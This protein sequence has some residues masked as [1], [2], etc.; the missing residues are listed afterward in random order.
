MTVQNRLNERLDPQQVHPT[1][2]RGVG[3]TIRK[4]LLQATRKLTIPQPPTIPG[5]REEGKHNKKLEE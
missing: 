4:Y 1:I 2:P 5:P 3:R